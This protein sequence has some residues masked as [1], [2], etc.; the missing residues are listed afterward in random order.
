LRSSFSILMTALSDIIFLMVPDYELFICCP[1]PLSQGLPLKKG[2]V[3]QGQGK[4]LSL[5]RDVDFC[6]PRP[7][8]KSR[9]TRPIAHE[10]PSSGTNP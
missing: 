10:H 1:P 2:S 7:E 4:R 3:R 9:L 8:Q 6:G 5:R